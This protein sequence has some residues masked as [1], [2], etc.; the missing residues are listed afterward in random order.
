M[1]PLVDFLAV[2]VV[3]AWLVFLPTVGLLYVMGAMN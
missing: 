2:I 3:V 1:K